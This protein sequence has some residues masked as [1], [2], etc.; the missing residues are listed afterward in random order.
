[1]S[2]YTHEQI[3]SSKKRVKKHA[4]QYATNRAATHARERYFLPALQ[5]AVNLWFVNYCYFEGVVRNII[6]KQI[7]S[8]LII[9]DVI[10]QGHRQ[11]ETEILKC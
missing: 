6:N 11:E 2:N 3:G 5:Y 8:N 4:H 10:N 7:N 1:M 9:W